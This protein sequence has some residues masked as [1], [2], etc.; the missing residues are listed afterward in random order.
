[1]VMEEPTLGYNLPASK[2]KKSPIPE[3]EMGL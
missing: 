2:D 1:M 3:K